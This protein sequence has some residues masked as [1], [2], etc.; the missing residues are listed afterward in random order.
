MEDQLGGV[1]RSLGP[2]V[3]GV[4]TGWGVDS[5][6][7][8]LIVAALGAAISAAWSWYTN[9][10]AAKAKSLAETPG[11][12]VEVSAIAPPEIKALAEDPAHQSI[13]MRAAPL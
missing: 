11:V 9:S 13:V 10:K 3:I 2:L 6:T 12:R 5:V 4:L 1:L 8:G 7:A